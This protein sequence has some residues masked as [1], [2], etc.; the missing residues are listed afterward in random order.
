MDRECCTKRWTRS[1]GYL[2]HKPIHNY[3]WTKDSKFS[4]G[5]DI[6]Q[7]LKWLTG[8]NWLGCTFSVN[9][10]NC[11]SI[12]LDITAD[13]RGR[14]SAGGN[15]ICPNKRSKKKNWKKISRSGEGNSLMLQH[16]FSQ[17]KGWEREKRSTKDPKWSGVELSLHSQARCHAECKHHGSAMNDSAKIL[18]WNIKWINDGAV[19]R[20]RVRERHKAGV[21]CGAHGLHIK[22][23][24]G[25]QSTSW[26]LWKRQRP[27]HR[28][29]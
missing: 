19:I 11:F 23:M 24:T 6:H 25:T 9:V 16:C 28:D 4:G 27:E 20:I 3:S 21:H 1:W 17:K 5:S 10:V 22:P 13:P 7:R 18:V 29:H 14:G 26:R 8:R 2:F 15:S 12:V